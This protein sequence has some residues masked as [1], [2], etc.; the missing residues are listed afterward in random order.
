MTALR[1]RIFAQALRVVL[2]ATVAVLMSML[3]WAG[4]TLVL[5][6]FRPPRLG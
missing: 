4:L 3:L 2:T 6:D 5:V 1:P